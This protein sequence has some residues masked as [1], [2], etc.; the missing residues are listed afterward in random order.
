M[1]LLVLGEST[2]PH[3]GPGEVRARSWYPEGM[4]TR[5]GLIHRTWMQ[6]GL[7][8]LRG[9]PGAALLCWLKKA[10]EKQKSW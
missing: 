3:P 5:V 10:S 9:V 6:M 4:E 7:L 2:A 1:Q 8:Y